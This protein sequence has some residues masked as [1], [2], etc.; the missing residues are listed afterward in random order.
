MC[1]NVFTVCSYRGGRAQQH[2][3]G[4]ETRSKS[5]SSPS[6][7]RWMG[8]LLRRRIVF[9][10]ESRGCQALPAVN[11]LSRAAVGTEACPYGVR[12]WCTWRIIIVVEKLDK[13]NWTRLVSKRPLATVIGCNTVLP[14]SMTY[15]DIV[16]T[17]RTVHRKRCANLPVSNGRAA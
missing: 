5:S 3:F 13:K 2:D 6:Q 15:Y 17:R 16:A 12:R 7:P 9:S 4:Q 10:M 14:G 1:T 11:E 8:T